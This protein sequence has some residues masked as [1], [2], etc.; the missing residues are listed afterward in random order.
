MS[1]EFNQTDGFFKNK[2]SK[3]SSENGKKQ[4]KGGKEKIQPSA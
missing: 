4:D 1:E 2:K 3:T